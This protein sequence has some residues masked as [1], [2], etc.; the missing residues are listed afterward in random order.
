MTD[1]ENIQGWMLPDSLDWLRER[2]RE[3]DTRAAEIGCWKGRSTVAMAQV[4]RP[5]AMLYAVDTWASGSHE[6]PDATQAYMEFLNNTV[7]FLNVV[8]CRMSS[9]NSAKIALTERLS[10][11]F[12]FIDADHS[13]EAV[14]ADIMAWYP[15]VRSGGILAGHDYITCPGVTRAVNEI[16]ADIPVERGPDSIWW[17]RV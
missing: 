14:C 12:V 7:G 11:D 10:F 3:V 9:L 4:M 8:A 6:Y 13:Y 16:F 1:A 2:A 5:Y 15:L 17:L